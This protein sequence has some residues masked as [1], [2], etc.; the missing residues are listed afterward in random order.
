MYYSR[1]NLLY[2]CKCTSSFLCLRNGSLAHCATVQATYFTYILLK[3]YL[4]CICTNEQRNFHFFSRLF[5]RNAGKPIVSPISNCSC[6]L[7]SLLKSDHLILFFHSSN[8][9]YS[10]PPIN[11]CYICTI[12]EGTY[13]TFVSI[14]A[15]FYGFAKVLLHNYFMVQATYCTYLLL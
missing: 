14:L 15:P 12:V 3:I 2:I 11:V 10:I 1:S 9:G 8:D 13:F 7:Q 6:C 4:L 5:I